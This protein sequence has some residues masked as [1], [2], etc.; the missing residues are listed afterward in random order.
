MAEQ[1]ISLPVA[2]A[3]EEQTTAL[4]ETNAELKKDKKR[5]RKAPKKASEASKKKAR[6]NLTLELSKPE[7]LQGTVRF[8]DIVL[9]KVGERQTMLLKGYS[10]GNSLFARKRNYQKLR[11]HQ[12][13]QQRELTPKRMK[14]Q[15][16][17][18]DTLAKVNL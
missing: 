4:P 11:L 9:V 7:F 3:E 5:K 17:V 13:H 12:K 15:Q 8:D 14:I 18:R 1:T 6:K 16:H 2:N 10:L